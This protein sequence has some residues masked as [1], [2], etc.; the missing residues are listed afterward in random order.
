[1][2]SKYSD[3]HSHKH[4]PSNGVVVGVVEVDAVG[5]GE[6]FEV[7]LESAEGEVFAG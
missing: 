1:M 4:L 6:V 3:A 7:V 2:N 5:V